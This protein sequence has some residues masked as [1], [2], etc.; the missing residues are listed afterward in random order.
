MYVCMYRLQVCLTTGVF[1][2]CKFISCI[3]NNMKKFAFTYGSQHSF[4]FSKNVLDNRSQQ[5]IAE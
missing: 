3:F 4:I 5:L 2:R 1:N